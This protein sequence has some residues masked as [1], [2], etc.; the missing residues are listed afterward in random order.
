MLAKPAANAIADIGIAVSSTRAFARCTRRVVAT[1][2]G[3]APAWRK[4]SRRTWR[5]VIPSLSARSSTRRPSSRN[6]R[7][8][9]L[10]AAETAPGT[11]AW[12]GAAA[13]VSRALRLID[14]GF[15]D[16]GQTVDDLADTLGMTAR[17]LRRL[18]VRHAGASPAAVAT[19]RRVQQPRSW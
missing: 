11:P 5:A 10:R 9:S 12:Q 1:A 17:H 15:L 16:E 7:S 2:V 6:P 4:N 14:R 19:T 3:G 18:F 13:T 8:M